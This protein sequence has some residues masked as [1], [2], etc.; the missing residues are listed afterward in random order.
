MLS[1]LFFIILASYVDD[2]LCRC[3]F[4]L[5]CY[6]FYACYNFS[7]C[8]Q[9]F[10]KS[11]GLECQGNAYLC[12]CVVIIGQKVFLQSQIVCLMVKLLWTTDMTNA[13]FSDALHN[14]CVQYFRTIVKC[15]MWTCI[16]CKVENVEV[17]ADFCGNLN[18]LCS[19]SANSFFCY[20]LFCWLNVCRF[21]NICTTHSKYD[22]ITHRQFCA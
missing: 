19:L 6:Q 3:Y 8:S 20:I 12:A 14:C 18:M 5:Q 7:R 9:L 15:K 22:A 2:K 1:F 21:M 11:S 17:T 16:K 13:Q 4:H 10:F